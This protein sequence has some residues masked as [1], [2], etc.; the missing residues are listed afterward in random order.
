MT[1]GLET[2]WDYSGRMTRK[3]KSKKWIKRVE[4]EKGKVKDTKI[5]EGGEKKG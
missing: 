1:S 3:W 2:Q 5:V 4:R